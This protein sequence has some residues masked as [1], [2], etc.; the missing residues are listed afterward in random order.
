MIV[1]QFHIPCRRLDTANPS[2]SLV[3][4]SPRLIGLL[5]GEPSSLEILQWTNT[6]FFY[7]RRIPR[8]TTCLQRSVL[9]GNVSGSQRWPVSLLNVA[10][11]SE[12]VVVIV[13]DNV[14]FEIDEK[15]VPHREEQR[16]KYTVY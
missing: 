1:L 8:R 14:V 15:R 7:P 10:E 3:R 12:V 6:I 2:S 11:T 16:E 13:V 9:L 4:G 5:S